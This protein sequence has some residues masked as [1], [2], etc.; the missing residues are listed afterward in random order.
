MKLYF[1]GGVPP[2]SETIVPHGGKVLLSFADDKSI[3]KFMDKYPQESFFLDSGAFSAAT[4][5]KEIDIDRY[6]A[7]IKKYKPSLDVY[8]TLD[9]IGDWQAT[10]ENTEYIE[11]KGL[12]PLP[13]FHYKSPRAELERMCAKYDY[14]ALGG[15]VPIAR[16]RTKLRSWLDFCFSVIGTSTKVHGLGMTGVW[17]LERYPFYSVDST[18]YLSA[19]RFGASSF[20]N[21]LQVLKY[22]NRSQH[23]LQRTQAEVNYWFAKQKEITKLWKMRGVDWDK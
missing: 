19:S 2:Y 5:G 21:N 14:I 11:S 18:A 10:V 4:V 6:I 9:V 8:A 7:F 12:E 3:V 20:E 1:A 17:C 23:Y 22:N 16:Q 15:L 13:V